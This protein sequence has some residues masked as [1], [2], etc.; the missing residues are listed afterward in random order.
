MPGCTDGTAA[1]AVCHL[2]ADL[3]RRGAVGR[4]HSCSTEHNRTYRDQ[5][6][7]RGHTNISRAS[8]NYRSADR[9]QLA[10]HG[11]RASRPT[12]SRLTC[13]HDEFA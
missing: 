11:H 7:R 8:R 3:Y 6:A 5:R 1:N 10:A 4:N 12:H 13:C 2:E 9:D